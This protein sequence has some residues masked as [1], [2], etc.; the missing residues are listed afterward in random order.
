MA[1]VVIVVE[2]T[3]LFVFCTC[4]CTCTESVGQLTSRV[5][6]LL[7][8][9]V[10]AWSFFLSSLA[11]AAVG[12]AP[13]EQGPG[14]ASFRPRPDARRHCPPSKGTLCVAAKRRAQRERRGRGGRRGGSV[15]VERFRSTA[16]EEAATVTEG[17]R[18]LL[19]LPYLA[20][21]C[22]VLLGSALLLFAGQG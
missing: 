8:R 18:V 10:R 13:G 16:G 19:F 6:F 15:D 21:P 14:R 7:L 9:S 17:G 22:C 3:N 4:T 20:V 12:G 1:S 5:F 11:A 2:S